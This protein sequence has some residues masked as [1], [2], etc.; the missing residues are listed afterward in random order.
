MIE[1]G[2]SDQEI[3]DAFVAGYGD[4]ILIVPDGERGQWLFT[5]P[6]IVVLLAAAAA[7]FRVRKMLAKNASP[8]RYVDP[9]EIEIDDA[10]LE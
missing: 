6:A 8:D 3:R 2:R 4:A 7:V 5:V 9:P 1:Q 10:E